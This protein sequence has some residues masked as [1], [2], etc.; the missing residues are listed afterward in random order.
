LNT[1][2]VSWVGAEWW[3]VLRCHALCYDLVPFI[4]N[5]VC[6]YD[7]IVVLLKVDNRAEMEH[8]QG[9]RKTWRMPSPLNP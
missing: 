2:H 3:Y 5:K 4:G 7:S 6:I 8:K 1:S 9:Q